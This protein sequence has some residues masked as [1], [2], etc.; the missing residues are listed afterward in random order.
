[1]QKAIQLRLRNPTLSEKE[2]S[3]GDGN[4]E[5]T[6]ITEAQ[7]ETSETNVVEPRLIG[8]VDQL[9]SLLGVSRRAKMTYIEFLDRLDEDTS[10][11][12]VHGELVM[13][14]P[15]GDR[16]QDIV[17]FLVSVLSVFSESHDLG[18][19]RPSP[20]QM[21]LHHGREPD[22][23]FVGKTHLD[24]LKDT[25]LDGPADLVVE[26]ISPESASRDRGEKFYE[27]EDAGIQE[28]WLIDP[29]R[30]KAEFYQSIAGRYRLVHGGESG[31]YHSLSMPGLWLKVEWL[32]QVP[33]PKVLDVLRELDLV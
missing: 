27:Y 13:T 10:A 21:K 23:L 1:V 22:L 5:N 11:E 2:L 30:R 8:Q 18:V 4:T 7:T 6:M 3:W 15:A 31:V 24:R 25:F 33:L 14:S 26:I 29:L 12:W 19:I 9:E 28:Y 16:H 20:F 32:W 17:R